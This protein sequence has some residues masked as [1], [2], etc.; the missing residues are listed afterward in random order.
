MLVFWWDNMWLFVGTV[1]KGIEY[2]QRTK[3]WYV[4]FVICPVF[5]SIHIWNNIYNLCVLCARMHISCIHVRS[6]V[7]RNVRKRLRGIEYHRTKRPT[8]IILFIIFWARSPLNCY[9]ILCFIINISIFFGRIFLSMTPM[10][11]RSFCST[12]GHNTRFLFF[13]GCILNANFTWRIIHLT[14]ITIY[15][16]SLNLQ[17]VTIW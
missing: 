13:T 5:L 17:E 16:T 8:K 10:I 3:D 11:F 2:R 15:E 12:V 7:P 9:L 14:Q 6:N 1:K 4:F